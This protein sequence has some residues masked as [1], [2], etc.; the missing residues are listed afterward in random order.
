MGSEASLQ[1]K[2]QRC[3]DPFRDSDGIVNDR[4][5]PECP[6]YEG[7]RALPRPDERNNNAACSACEKGRCPGRDKIPHPFRGDQAPWP[8]EIL[9]H[10]PICGAEWVDGDHEDR[11]F[12]CGTSYNTEGSGYMRFCDRPGGFDQ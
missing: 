12:A 7:P 5:W 9:T 4:H 1:R 3:G 8:D 2:C 10:C 6:T 11:Y